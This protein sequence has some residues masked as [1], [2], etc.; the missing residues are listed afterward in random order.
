LCRNDIKTQ[1][2]ASD[3]RFILSFYYDPDD[4]AGALRG[5]KIQSRIYT[6]NPVPKQM[7]IKVNNKRHTQEG[8]G[9]CSPKPPQT[10]PIHR[11]VSD[12]VKLCNQSSCVMIP[13]F[14][15]EYF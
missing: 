15:E 2:Y 7:S 9:V 12:F 6:S 11:S 1:P 5:T 14:L 3:Y 13:F 8:T 10:P 4:P